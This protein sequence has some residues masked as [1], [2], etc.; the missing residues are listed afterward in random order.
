MLSYG[1]VDGDQISLR[2]Q[3]DIEEMFR[4]CPGNLRGVF[5]LTAGNASSNLGARVS[6]FA[7]RVAQGGKHVA[8]EA[9]VLSVRGASY[10]EHHWNNSPPEAAVTAPV[11]D[12]TG[13]AVGNDRSRRLIAPPP[14]AAAEVSEKKKKEEEK[15][16]EKKKEE[17]DGNE[18]QEKEA[19]FSFVDRIAVTGKHIA[20]EALVLGVRGVSYV[21]HRWHTANQEKNDR[22]E[23]LLPAAEVSAPAA[24]VSVPAAEVFSKP[25]PPATPPKPL[26]LCDSWVHFVPTPPAPLLSE[27]EKKKE[28]LLGELR[29]MGFSDQLRNE[30]A[31]VSA[32]YSLED[33]VAT[34]LGDM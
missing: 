18:E 4:S 6:S 26:V 25:A 34:L 7:S 5:R 8:E 14:P 24:E 29:A 19:E 15:K 31:L 16:N 28:R 22:A 17:E 2:T 20:E 23:V 30:A 12:V 3:A 11:A 27:E 13:D 33:A 9:I 10:L 32:N 21:E 1:D